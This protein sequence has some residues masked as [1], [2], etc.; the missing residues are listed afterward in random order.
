MTMTEEIKTIK[1]PET[2]RSIGESAFSWCVNLNSINIPTDITEIAKSITVENGTKKKKERLK[3]YL[4]YAW[5]QNQILST[6]H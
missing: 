3:T 5:R 1:L 2:I 6:L 4:L